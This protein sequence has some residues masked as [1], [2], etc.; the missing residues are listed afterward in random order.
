M[1]L[2]AL[3]CRVRT[4]E[5]KSGLRVVYDRE[6]RWREPICAMASGTVAAIFPLGELSPMALH[7]AIRAFLEAFQSEIHHSALSTILD[8][9]CM[10][11]FARRL[12]VPTV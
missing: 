1:A 10:T 5:L 9:R 11:F 8:K 2:I 3:N 6:G 12:P 4:S 7:M